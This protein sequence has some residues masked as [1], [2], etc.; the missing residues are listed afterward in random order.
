MTVSVDSL[1]V[2]FDHGRARFILP[3]L[4]LRSPHMVQCLAVIRNEKGLHARPSTQ[5]VEAGKQYQA[6]VILHYD[7]YDANA[8]RLLELLSLGAECG[9]E[10]Q[11]TADGPDEED[12]L[13]AIKALVEQE[14]DLD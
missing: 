4:F 12:A 13:E 11:I 8:S 2:I 14:Y 5:V 10:I 7:G 6:E 3:G 1:M 9:A